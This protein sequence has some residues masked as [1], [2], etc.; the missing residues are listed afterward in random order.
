M[1][2]C[3]NPKPEWHAKDTTKRLDEKAYCESEYA[4]EASGGYQYRYERGVRDAYWIL[5]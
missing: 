2:Y 3:L 5:S 4:G 1:L